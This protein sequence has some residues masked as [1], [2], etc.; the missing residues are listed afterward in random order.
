MIKRQP[1]WLPFFL[2]HQFGVAQGT[3]KANDI[4]LWCIQVFE[5]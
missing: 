5:L 3:K 2:D 4:E 1:L